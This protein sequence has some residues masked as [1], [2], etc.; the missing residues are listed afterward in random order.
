MNTHSS[1]MNLKRGFIPSLDDDSQSEKKVKQ[2]EVDPLK[3]SKNNIDEFFVS[4]DHYETDDKSEAKL[5]NRD[6][7]E[8]GARFLPVGSVNDMMVDEQLIWRILNAGR[9]VLI[10]G[11]AGSGKSHLLTRWIQNATGSNFVFRVTSPT[12]IAAY[13]IKGETIH[14]AL[15]LGLAQ[16]DPVTLFKMITKDRRKFNRTW[17]FL[18]ETKVLVID[19]ISMVHGEFFTKL[20]Y[21]FRKANLPERRFGGVLLI[22]V[23]DFTQLGPIGD[24]NASASE[25][26]NRFV[27]DS[28][29]FQLMQFSR[30]F[31]DRNYRQTKGPFLTLLNEIR[32][33]K[34]SDESKRI[35]LSRTNVDLDLSTSLATERDEEGKKKKIEIHPLDIF[36]YKSQVEKCNSVNLKRLQDGGAQVKRFY[37]NL[38]TRKK[39]HVQFAEE[40]DMKKAQFFIS[41]DGIKQLEEFFPFFHVTLAEGAQVMLRTN[42][43]IDEGLCNGSLGVVT[44][45]ED[46]AV[47]VLFVVNGKFLDTPREITRSDF[48]ASVGKTAEVVMTQFPLTLAWSSTIH[49]CCHAETMLY[50]PRGLCTIGE[51]VRDQN[52]HERHI[53]LQTSAHVLETTSQAY[54]SAQPEPSVILVTASGFRLEAGFEHVILVEEQGVRKWRPMNSIQQGDLVVMKRG[55]GSTLL[56]QP[57]PFSVDVSFFM[58]VLCGLGCFIQTLGKDSQMTIPVSMVTHVADV[59]QRCFPDTRLVVE[60][61]PHASFMLG[62]SSDGKVLLLLERWGFGSVSVPWTIMTGASDTQLAFWNGLQSCNRPLSWTNE[63]FPREL[64]QMLL[65]NGIVSRVTRTDN[66]YFLEVV[67]DR[68]SSSDNSFLERVTGISTGRCIMYDLTVPGSNTYLSNGMISHNCQGLTLDRVRLDASNMFD[69]GMLYV[70]LSRVRELEHL[71]LFAFKEKSLLSDPRAVAFETR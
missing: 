13:N 68:N 2:F 67:P 55:Y 15:G 52:W 17:K 27:L 21:L 24:R 48:F 16:D 63:T 56:S 59:F 62:K 5:P 51:L 50:L 38:T 70:A 11:I 29:A 66:K 60:P 9:N 10:S 8:R 47:H 33:G 53:Q 35:L 23:G 6:D 32:V 64:Q 36:P 7:W 20:E 41:R 49:K 28:E 57:E 45:I 25:F 26:N 31:L 1:E 14:R 3:I 71:S 44:S 65:Y 30:L 54:R 40:E 46:N 34:L 18:N 69:S 43:Y 19:E 42:L 12:G 61:S 4:F 37:P 22:L 39:E 58:G